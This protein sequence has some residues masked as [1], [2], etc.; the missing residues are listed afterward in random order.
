MVKLFFYYITSYFA[1]TDDEIHCT[2]F[3]PTLT[4][5]APTPK[6]T[7]PRSPFRW[8]E[9]WNVC[10]V[11]MLSE[12]NGYFVVPLGEICVLP[13]SSAKRLHKI[14]P[15]AKCFKI[16]P[17]WKLVSKW[18]PLRSIWPHTKGLSRDLADKW[19]C[20]NC[21]LKFYFI[22]QSPSIFFLVT[23]FFIYSIGWIEIIVKFVSLFFNLLFESYILNYIILIFRVYF[24]Y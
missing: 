13:C 3:T 12:I 6:A 20:S 2:P 8:D 23:F 9:W 19:S 10:F 4:H 21:H 7:E 18:N 14:N 24:K 11:G 15:N 22:G 1:S 5:T 16:D 17:D